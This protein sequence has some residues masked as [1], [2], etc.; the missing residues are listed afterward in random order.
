VEND[1]CPVSISV[2]DKNYIGKKPASRP[3]VENFLLGI[4]NKEISKG[5]DIALN[6][7]IWRGVM[8]SIKV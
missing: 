2:H 5:A 1:R 4:K 8:E 6:P 7:E 3:T